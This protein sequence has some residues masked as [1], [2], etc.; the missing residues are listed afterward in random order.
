M[1]K[2]GIKIKKLTKNA[3]IPTYGTANAA[4]ADLY[5]CIEGVLKIEA[6]ET[7]FVSTGIA[8]EIP[9]GL[10][11]LVYARSGL[12]SKQ[13]LA[14]ANKVGVIDSDY[15]GEIIVALH[16]HSKEAKTIENGQRIAQIVFAPYI[17]GDFEEVES[18]EESVRGE[19][20]FGSTG[21]K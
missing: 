13:G 5:A 12:G 2:I 15:R 4:G 11:G 18:L 21:K 6:G 16:N 20:R 10:V 1:Q 3:T 19:G 9:E 8:L 14:P 7:K 17:M